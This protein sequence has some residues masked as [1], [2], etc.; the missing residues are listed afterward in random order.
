SDRLYAL[1][2]QKGNLIDKGMGSLDLILKAKINKNFGID[3]A[4]R[5]ILNPEFKRV[6]ENASGPV[7]AVTYKRGAFFSLGAKYT[8]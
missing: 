5:N 7:D 8:F 4:A 6:Q 2:S 1:G 3:F